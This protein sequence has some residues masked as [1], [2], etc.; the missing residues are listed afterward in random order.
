MYGGGPRLIG[1]FAYYLTP[2]QSFMDIFYNPKHA[3]FYFAFIMITCALF[4]KL[5]LEMSGRST[6]DVVKQISEQGLFIQ[7]SKKE[8]MVKILNKY[9]PTAAVFG[10]MCIGALTIVADLLGAIGSGTLSLQKAQESYWS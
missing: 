7:G 5:W 3:I 6:G 2:P 1:G 10:G 8:S 4:S 9:I